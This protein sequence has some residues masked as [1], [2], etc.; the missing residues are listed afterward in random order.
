MFHIAFEEMLQTAMSSVALLV[1]STAAAYV[2]SRYYL[3]PRAT[4][5]TVVTHHLLSPAGTNWF[6]SKT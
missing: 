4:V 2:Q 6:K 5:L 3:D 1:Y